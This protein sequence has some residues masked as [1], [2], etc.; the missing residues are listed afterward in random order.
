MVYYAFLQA[1]SVEA[2]VSVLDSYS[3]LKVLNN[4]NKNGLRATY[5]PVFQEERGTRA[6]VLEPT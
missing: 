6:D 5:L 3:S 1:Q 2:F 4:E